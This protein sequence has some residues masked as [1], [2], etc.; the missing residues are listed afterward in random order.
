MSDKDTELLKD[1]GLKHL[2][3]LLI[4]IAYLPS[5]FAMGAKQPNTL[6]C[7]TFSGGYGWGNSNPQSPL[8]ERINPFPKKHKVK[9]GYSDCYKEIYKERDKVKKDL[10]Q[11]NEQIEKK[12]KRTSERAKEI[13]RK[14]DERISRIRERTDLGEKRQSRV[15]DRKKK[16]DG[17]YKEI[18]RKKWRRINKRRDERND[19]HKLL[20]LCLVTPISLKITSKN[21]YQELTC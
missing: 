2:L 16:A 4:L 12:L 6:A 18:L 1:Q 14:V 9:H 17:F 19:K 8:L 15:F 11:L 21:T 10:K 5:A 20:I 7:E 3:I 13:S